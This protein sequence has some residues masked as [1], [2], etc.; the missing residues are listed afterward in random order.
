[1]PCARCER[2]DVPLE[3]VTGGF[4]GEFEIFASLCQRCRTELGGTELGQ[5]A[6]RMWIRSGYIAMLQRR[7]AGPGTA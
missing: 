6:A 2:T 3:R 7:A 5:G 1:M 4:V